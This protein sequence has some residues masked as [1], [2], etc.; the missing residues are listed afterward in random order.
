M[1]TQTLNLKHICLLA[2]ILAWPALGGAQVPVDEAGNPVADYEP[3]AVAGSEEL[4]IL[5]G[6]ELEGLIGPIALYPDD[7][8]AIVLPASTYPLQIVQA[9]RFPWSLNS[10][11]LSLQSNDS[12]TVPMPLEI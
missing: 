6:S 3:E 9:A 11:Q 5:S 12:V 7:L 2:A 10:L 1:S 4:G 8:L